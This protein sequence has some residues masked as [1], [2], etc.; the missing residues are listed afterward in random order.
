MLFG[1]TNASSTFQSL[2]N[3]IFKRYLRKFVLVFFDDI[4]IYSSSWEDHLQHVKFVLDILRSHNLFLKREKC[5]FG[6]THA[7]QVFGTFDRCRG[8]IG[9]SAKGGCHDGVAET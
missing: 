5:Q 6:Q 8:G 1:L 2:M 3:D 7:N 9:G 4:L